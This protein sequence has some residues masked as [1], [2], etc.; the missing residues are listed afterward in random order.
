MQTQHPETD[1][2]PVVFDALVRF[3]AAAH[4][5]EEENGSEGGVAGVSA[6]SASGAL[7]FR[8]LA[9]ED[10]PLTQVA[11]LC[12]VAKACVQSGD[13]ADIWQRG[14]TTIVHTSL[15]AHRVSW[16][17]KRLLP[18]HFEFS[19][20]TRSEP[21]H[22]LRMIRASNLDPR[23]ASF[24][25]GLVDAMTRNDDPIVFLTSSLDD[26]HPAVA[27]FDANVVSIGGIEREV[28]PVLFA[29]RYPELTDGQIEELAS[30]V[31]DL[32]AVPPGDIDCVVLAFRQSDPN[33][34]PMMI[35]RY[36]EQS[37]DE[38]A[39]T[40]PKLWRPSSVVPLNDLVGLGA[41]KVAAQDALGALRDWQAGLLSWNAVPRGLLIA[42]PAGTG[43]TELARSLAGEAGVHL[44]VASYNQWQKAGSLSHFLTAM[45]KSFDEAKREAPSILFIDEV[46]SFYTRTDL[47]GDGRN[48]SYDVKAIAALLEKLDGISDREGV[49]VVGACNHLKFVD[50]AIRRAGRFDVVVEIGL[51]TFED[52]E[53]ILGQHLGGIASGIDLTACAAAAL[54]RTGAD[55]AAAVRLAGATARRG[56]RAMTTDDVLAALEGDAPKMSDE[57]WLRLAVHEC[58]HAIVATALTAGSIE[59]ARIGS[60]GG[61]CKVAVTRVLQ[62]ENDLHLSRCVALA[63]REAERLLYGSIVVG[64]GGVVDSDIAKATRSASNQ[65]CSFGMGSLGP[66]WLAPAGSP[67]SVREAVSGHLPEVAE[68]LQSAE[69]TARNLLVEHR[70]VLVEMASYLAQTKVLYGDDLDRYL[71]RVPV[72]ER[73]TS[74]MR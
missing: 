45:E 63:G 32:S 52:L 2:R 24:E 11:A 38:E 43:K 66:I 12:L 57:E 48:D 39:S 56:N 74:A 18:D 68:L 21:H 41:A 20:D 13:I 29:I 58:G 62:T 7:D 67:S 3:C 44:V 28:L 72:Q 36:V 42:G 46:D 65:I 16:S 37:L 33:V 70:D 55:C 27:M 26:L 8:N 69:T 19:W 35:A 25:H 50:P 49:I 10:L 64:S 6:P 5:P 1:W 4:T 15:D 9:G 61:E 40:E 14:A 31:P 60:S 71:A 73:G 59:Y 34:V 23:R 51:P 22:V 54:G 17:W 47:S 30:R 53:V